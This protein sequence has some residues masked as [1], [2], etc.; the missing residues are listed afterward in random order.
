MADLLGQ[1]R[2]TKRKISTLQE[3]SPC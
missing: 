3:K 1:I 2:A